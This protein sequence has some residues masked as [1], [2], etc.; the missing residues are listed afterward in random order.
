MTNSLLTRKFKDELKRPWINQLLLWVGIPLLALYISCN[1]YQ[2]MLIQGRSMVPTYDHLQMVVLNRYDREYAAGDVVAFRCE[3]LA[4][5]LV[6]RI[7]ACPGD[8]AVIIDGTLYVNDHVSEVY[9]MQGA[10]QYSGLLAEPI[11][12]QEKQYLLL[13]DNIAKSKDSRYDEVGLV[14]EIDIIGRVC[15]S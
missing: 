4:C 3:A 14:H 6:K 15:G 11:H 1:W 10:F 9:P 13:G 12:L 5:V 8:S 2:L 7:A